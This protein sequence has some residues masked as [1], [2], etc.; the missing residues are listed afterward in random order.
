MIQ[1]IIKNKPTRLFLVLAG[2]FIANALIAELMGV[3]LFSFE[4]TFGLQPANLNI[5]GNSFS[6]NLSAGVLLSGHRSTRAEPF[7]IRRLVPRV[8]GASREID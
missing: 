6:Y 7:R 1:T 4:E 5:F 8:Y 2:F 3:K